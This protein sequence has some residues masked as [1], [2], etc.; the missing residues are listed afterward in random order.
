M[1]HPIG[2]RLNATLDDRRNT[3]LLV[4]QLVALFVLPLF[5]TPETE[6]RSFQISV[7]IVLAASLYAASARRAAL[8]IALALLVPTAFAWFGPDLLPGQTDNVLRMMTISASLMFT[9]VILVQALM[10]H[11][12]VTRE[13]LLGGV[14]VYLLLVFAFALVHAS[15]E[16]AHHG[17]YTVGGEPLLDYVDSTYSGRSFPTIIYFSVTTLTTLGYGDIVPAT[18]RA[19]MLT[20]LEALIGQLYIAIFIGRLVGIQ[21][22][23]R[24]AARQAAQQ[25]HVQTE[26]VV[27]P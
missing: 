7:L 11:D 13:T 21:V 22:G 14:N 26:E 15:V 12:T 9:A 17:S 25:E 4:A 20:S 6:P 16:V 24:A 18:D 5:A 2:Q 23:E 8:I 10:R 27:G 19:R 3:S 1:R